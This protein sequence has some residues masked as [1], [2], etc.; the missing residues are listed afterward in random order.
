MLSHISHA[1]SYPFLIYQFAYLASLELNAGLYL[2]RPRR[3]RSNHCA[4]RVS[5]PLCFIPR[6]WDWFCPRHPSKS[7][8]GLFGSSNCFKLADIIQNGF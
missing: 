2:E 7:W 3:P 4:L 5:N 8:Q 1:S 6:L